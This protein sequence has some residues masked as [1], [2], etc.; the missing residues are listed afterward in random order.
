MLDQA[1]G[2]HVNVA[3]APLVTLVN[4]E[5]KNSDIFLDKA[6]SQDLVLYQ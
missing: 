4:S 2:A 6:I 1:V 3:F 5:R